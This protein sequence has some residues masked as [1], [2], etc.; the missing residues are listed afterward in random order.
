MR[1]FILLVLLADI[2]AFAFANIPPRKFSSWSVLVTIIP[3]SGFYFY[4]K[5]GPVW[6]AKND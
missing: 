2:V 3:G 5:Y 6:K 4:L 1:E